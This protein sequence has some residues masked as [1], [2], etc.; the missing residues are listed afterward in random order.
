[1]GIGNFNNSQGG[2]GYAPE[3]DDKD[4]QMEQAKKREKK[5]R[6]PVLDNFGSNLIDDARKGKIDPVVG[7]DEEINQLIQILNKRKKNNPLLVG[8]PGVGKSAVVEGLALKILNKDID[9]SFYDKKIIKLELASMVAGTKYR[10][11]FEERMVAIMTEAKNNPEVILFLDEIHTIV[12]AGGAS[13]SLDAANMLKPPLAKGEFTCIG[14]TTFDEYQK[15]FEKD[16]AL[17]RRFQKIT[18]NPPSREE[19]IEILKNIKSKY[20]EH[21]GVNYSSGIMEKIVDLSNRYIMDRNNPDKS[22]DLMDEVGS[23][24]TLNHT[25]IIP[26]GLR[27]LRDSVRDVQDRKFK[28]RDEQDY[29]LA[30]DLKEEEGELTIILEEKEGEF[31][32]ETKKSEGTRV[33]IEDVAEII[34]KHTGIPITN[35]KDDDLERVSKME[36]IIKKTLISQDKAVKKVSEAVQRSRTGIRDPKKPIGSF[37]F[38]G[39]TGVGKCFVKDSTIKIKNK[40]TGEIEEVSVGEFRDM[41]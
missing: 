35:L 3:D 20:E 36:P 29:E 22:I 41:I 18:I 27:K 40:S 26:E 7:R 11:Q 15:H 6:T 24:I 38:L 30:A 13:G 32:Q 8:E 1:M 31:K 33:T 19:T 14:A 10:G 37:L 39:P 9:E 17:A 21:H 16:K 4:F 25:P 34:S 2:D 28:A 5:S 23:R 12:G